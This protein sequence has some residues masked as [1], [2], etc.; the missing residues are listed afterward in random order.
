MSEKVFLKDRHKHCHVEAW[1][2][3][4]FKVCELREDVYMIEANNSTLNLEKDDKI[5]GTGRKHWR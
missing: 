1:T 5:G 2:L 3:Y 4:I